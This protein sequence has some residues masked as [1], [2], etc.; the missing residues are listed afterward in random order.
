[1]IGVSEYVDLPAWGISRMRAKIDTGALSCALHVENI[2]ERAG[3]VRFEVRLHRSHR[4]KRVA[5][6]AAVARRGLVRSSN[7]EVEKRLFVLAP[8]RIGNVT[9]N[10]ELGLVDRRSMI[11]RMLIGRG[12]L[13]RGFLVDPGRRFVLGAEPSRARSRPV[14]ESVRAKARLA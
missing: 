11:Y 4:E 3:R 7:G 8:V 13:A 12:A 10:V 9:R 5:V 1:V 14:T 6:E 2:K